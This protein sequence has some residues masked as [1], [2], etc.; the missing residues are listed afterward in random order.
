MNIT[1]FQLP[2]IKCNTSQSASIL[3]IL[4]H[5]ILFTRTIGMR[6]VAKEID[7][8]LFD[9][10]VYTAIHDDEIISNVKHEI[11]HICQTREGNTLPLLLSLYHSTKKYGILGEYHEKLEFERWFITL[12][13]VLEKTFAEETILEYQIR[14][15]I[16][17]IISVEDLPL[18]FPNNE[19]F[20]F[21]IVNTTPK[22][23]GLM[24]DMFASASRMFG[25]P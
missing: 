21:S 5:T 18:Q 20:S 2:T 6:V 16:Q 3:E 1:K 4:I 14:D 11:I 7:S 23:N 15:A 13:Y 10:L 25:T 17:T 8:Y 12:E 9:D 24:Y 19:K 22:Q